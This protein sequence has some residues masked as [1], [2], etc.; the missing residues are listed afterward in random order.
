MSSE[1]SAGVHRRIYDRLRGRYVFKIGLAV[2]VVTAALLAVGFMTLGQVEASVEADAE[3]TLLAAAE[4]EADGIDGFIEDRNDD[5]VRLSSDA[6]IR[7]GTGSEIREELR[8]A[9]DALPDHVEG[10]HYY[11][12]EDQR[13]L[14][15]AEL[16]REGQTSDD[17]PYAV[18]PETFDGH[19]DVRSFEPYM[20]GVHGRLAFM[21]PIEGEESHAIVITADLSE[22]G[23]LLESPVDGGTLEVVSTETGDVALAQNASVLLEE[24]FLGESLT[25]LD[26]EV[27]ESRIDT[28]A[29]HREDRIEDDTVVVA[30]AP[31]ETKPWVVT[32][33]APEGGLY[34]T[35]GDVAQ[36][37]LILIGVSVLGLA[38]L[39]VVV[40]RDVNGS[41]DEMR[42][43]AEEI[44]AGNLDVA[45]DRSRTDEFGGIAD[46]LARLRDTLREQI[47]EAE[48]RAA[49]AAAAEEEAQELT[50]HLEAKADHYG[51]VIDAATAGDLTRR[52][53][54]E[55]RS[56]AMASIGRSLNEMLGSV[57]SLVVAIQ[58][59]AVPVGERSAAVSADAEAVESRSAEVAH[60]I[61]EISEGTDRQER[62][63]STAAAEL[64][65]L[66]ATVEE[67]ASST[68]ETAARAED[69]VEIGKNGRRTARSAIDRMN[70]I[71][72]GMSET[73]EEMSTLR[74]EVRRI[75]EVVELIDEIAERTNILAL[76]ASIEAARAGESGAGFAVVA[77]EVKSLAEETATATTEVEDLIAD[78]EE[79]TES[80]AADM[81]AMEDDVTE[82]RETVDETVSML[83]S[84]VEEI[85][86]ANA[87]IQSINDATDEQA[88]STQEV[89]AMVDEVASV[90]EQTAAEAQTVSAAAEEQTV[91][92]ERIAES[93]ES[94][95]DRSAEL[96][97]LVERFETE[98]AGTGPKRPVE[99]GEGVA[100]A[101]GGSL[102]DAGSEDA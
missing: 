42:G 34:G 77:D 65:D 58:D 78:V 29:N 4:R 102:S 54:P 60:S 51:E 69:A 39:G 71:E 68:N 19:E 93:A 43:Y 99:P 41:L 94:L 18:A 6:R 89:V 49:E 11:D 27:T 81:F 17:R 20:A 53:D 16:I 31:M 40:S 98:A 84:I 52:L 46:L 25:H 55:S 100:T 5:A 97:A 9:R 64:N 10:I 45:I 7:D 86:D 85:A 2:I 3:E 96:R 56:E 73:V 101:D 91:A 62:S 83:A 75:G 37:V 12:M 35:V 30:S 87:S 15:S 66:S 14:Y 74:D 80:V 95:S 1:G 63:L 70:R 24:Y 8:R 33:A 76:N 48:K 61:E 21:S 38:M 44:E 13:I 57:E 22:R 79:S 23:A 59:A 50:A 92:T 88:N 32:V 26:D 82:G 47:H 67:I 90:S 72:S 28:A 36:S